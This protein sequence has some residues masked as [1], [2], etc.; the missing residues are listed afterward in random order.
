V[1][2]H[3]EAAGSDGLIVGETG[4]EVEMAVGT[5]GRSMMI[6]EVVAMVAAVGKIDRTGMR[7]KAVGERG[8]RM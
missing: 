3:T 1:V 7:S 2:E 5:S 6:G 8:K 4:T